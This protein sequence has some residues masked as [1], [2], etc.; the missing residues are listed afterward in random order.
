MG[1]PIQ[2]RLDAL[3]PDSYTAF[4]YARANAFGTTYRSEPSEY[5]LC[6]NLQGIV[7]CE[8]KFNLYQF[9]STLDPIHD[10]VEPPSTDTFIQ[11]TRTKGI[12]IQRTD[13]F[14]P[15]GQNA[16]K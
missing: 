6:S 5:G 14:V 4:A 8:H 7:S 12:P 10:S 3:R 15:S 13:I 1:D 9:V 11:R 16:L 2:T